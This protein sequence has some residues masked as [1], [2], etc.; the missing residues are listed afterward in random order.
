MSQDYSGQFFTELDEDGN[1]VVYTILTRIEP[2]DSDS[3]YI[4]FYEDTEEDDIQIEAAEVI[5]NEDGSGE[6]LYEIET[7]EEWAM[8]EEVVNTIM[9]L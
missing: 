3:T 8:I 2:D 5:E 6:Q 9:S 4:V 1:E 7:E